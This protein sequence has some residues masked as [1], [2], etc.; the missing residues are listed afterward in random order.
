ME[1]KDT[2]HRILGI[3]KEDILKIADL[4]EILDLFISL[5][6]DL[7]KENNK[8]IK[9]LVEGKTF[10]YFFDSIENDIAT[11][12]SQSKYSVDSL[13][14]KTKDLVNEQNKKIID[15]IKELSDSFTKE[16]KDIKDN[17]PESVDLT[18]IEDTITKIE[19]RLSSLKD[20]NATDIRDRLESLKG[21][22][23]LD[24]SAIK[25]LEDINLSKSGNTVRV[26][27]TGGLLTYVNAVKK[28][29]FKNVNFSAG[30]GVTITHSVVNGQDT[31]TFSSTGGG[32]ANIYSELLASVDL[33]QSGDNVTY[34]AADLS[35][36]P[37]DT[38]LM[39]SRNGIIMVLGDTD[40]GYTTSGTGASTT[41][42][43]YNCTT[44]D[45]FQIIYTY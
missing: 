8:Q 2:L 9:D 26:G 41:F 23:R 25:G 30:T 20:L 16:I 21:D 1:N 15:N 36:V 39:V 45:K 19:L 42:T 12:K 32:S 31:L 14:V 44:S 34:S 11:L 37:L 18:D 10:K 24:V 27:G 35:N 29:T 5:F 38:V 4:Q 28:G 6:E 7:K 43:F 33:V 17:L 40:N 3:R 13:E 22:D